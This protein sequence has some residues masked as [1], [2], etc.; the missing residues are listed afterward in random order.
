M[1]VKGGKEMESKSSE[2]LMRSV[3]EYREEQGNLEAQIA[4]MKGQY[5]SE[6]RVH[7]E[8]KKKLEAMQMDKELSKSSQR[9]EMINESIKEYDK[10]I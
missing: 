3:E 6:K 1:G 4:R 7:E 9:A 8:S 10:E 5:E 2:E